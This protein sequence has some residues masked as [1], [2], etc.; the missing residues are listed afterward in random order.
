MYENPEVYE[1]TGGRE[2]NL[3]DVEAI[4]FGEVGDHPPP[5]RVTRTRGQP[6][7]S[8]Q[9]VFSTKLFL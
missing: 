3:T 8:L 9:G 7:R 1:A 2:S 6:S 4:T 5:Q